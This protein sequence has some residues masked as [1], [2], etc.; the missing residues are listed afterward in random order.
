MLTDLLKTMGRGLDW[1]LGLGP[2]PELN[3]KIQTADQAKG[4]NR[5]SITTHWADMSLEQM[6]KAM[7]QDRS[8]IPAGNPNNLAKALRAYIWHQLFQGVSRHRARLLTSPAATE[9]LWRQLLLPA[10]LLSGDDPQA[11]Y[12]ALRDHALRM[13]NFPTLEPGPGQRIAEAHERHCGACAQRFRLRIM[14]TGAGPE[15]CPDCLRTEQE[16]E[17]G[18]MPT[19]EAWFE[20]RTRQ[21][22][23]RKKARENEPLRTAHEYYGQVVQDRHKIIRTDIS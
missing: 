17:N 14:K 5:T 3:P 20:R 12:Q 22:A 4:A 23:K 7:Q 10:Q 1:A 9:A 15:I 8:K 2:K 11:A 18:W 13:M 6:R 19:H 21:I 16:Y